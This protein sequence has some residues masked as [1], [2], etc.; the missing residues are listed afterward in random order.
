MSKLEVYVMA[1]SIKRKYVSYPLFVAFLLLYLK[2]LTSQK[3]AYRVAY[4]PTAILFG[5][6]ITFS[7][8]G[9]SF[10]SSADCAVCVQLLGRTLPR[11][12]ML[13]GSENSKAGQP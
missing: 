4:I 10:F 6:G 2:C 8:D 9:L 3:Y 1:S 7:V 5:V 12:F 11:G 13:V